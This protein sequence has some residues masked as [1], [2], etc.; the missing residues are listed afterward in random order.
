MKPQEYPTFIY[1]LKLAFGQKWVDN[2]SEI[3][4][5]FCHV[6]QEGMLKVLIQIVGVHIHP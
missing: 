3:L 2:S 5:L 1:F 4:G 6:S